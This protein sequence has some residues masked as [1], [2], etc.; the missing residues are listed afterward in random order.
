MRRR[1]RRRGRPWRHC[2]RGRPRVRDRDARA[3]HGGRVVRDGVGVRQVR[4][5]QAS[6]EE[7]HDQIGGLPGGVDVAGCLRGFDGGDPVGVDWLA[8]DM[9]FIG[10]EPFQL[11]PGDHAQVLGPVEGEIVDFTDEFGH[12]VGA[13]LHRAGFRTGV[14]GD[15]QTAH[16]GIT[17]I[18]HLRPSANPVPRPVSGTEPAGL[19]RRHPTPRRRVTART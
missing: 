8:V 7:Q 1:R 15:G 9:W 17:G 14:G 13:Q 10:G 16:P 2:R 11:R 19:A 5:G 12:G 18:S 6:R 4:P 3:R